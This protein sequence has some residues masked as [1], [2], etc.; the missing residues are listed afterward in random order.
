GAGYIGGAT[1]RLLLEQDFEVTVLDDL[2]RGHRDA[3]PPAARLVVGNIA[4]AA[5]LDELFSSGP[6]YAIMHFAAFAEVGESMADPALY[7]RNNTAATLTLLEA[8]LRHR[9]ARF[10]FSSSC[11]VF[12]FPQTLP[13]GEDSPKLPVNPYGESKLQTE[14]M[15]EWFRRIH[16]LRYAVLRYF[17]AA[18]AWDGHCERHDPESHLIPNV[19]RAAQGSAGPV[20]IFGT[21]YPTADGTCV[22]DYI[23]IFDLA[24]AHLLVARALDEADQRIYNLGTGTGY[25]IREVISAAR[26]VTGREVPFVESARR[27]GDPPTLVASPAKIRREL[28]W[29]PQ[30]ATLDDMLSSAWR[31]LPWATA[32]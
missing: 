1:V 15:L 20:R 26:R 19:L 22:R 11:S 9:I 2:S 18:G 24:Q 12:G 6:F 7:F 5:L 8:C 28:G 16:G 21:D 13:I 4:D 29:S 31:A 23:H 3:V 10:V 32:G 25:S 14:I 17:N 27:P 30:Y